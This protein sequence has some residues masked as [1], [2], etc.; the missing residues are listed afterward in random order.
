M[1]VL[2]LSHVFKLGFH[3]ELFVVESYSYFMPIFCYMRTQNDVS[4][5][6]R[7]LGTDLHNLETSQPQVFQY[8]RKMILSTLQCFVSNAHKIH[9]NFLS[10]N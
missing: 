7:A 4:K 1:H 6:V 9:V 10:H 5:R 2:G 3:R 8:K